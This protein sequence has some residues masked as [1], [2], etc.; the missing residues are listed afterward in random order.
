MLLVWWEGNRRTWPRARMSKKKD[1]QEIQLLQCW[2]K[3]LN[4]ATFVGGYWT[5]SAR[6]VFQL[7]GLYSVMLL[8]F[9][10]SCEL[11]NSNL[12]QRFMF[13]PAVRHISGPL[14]KQKLTST[15]S[16]GHLCRSW[17][18]DFDPF[19]FFCVSRSV[20]CH[21]NFDWQQRKTQSSVGLW[22][23]EFACYWKQQ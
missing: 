10:I 9:S 6:L 22:T 11:W 4:L 8:R 2:V 18:V 1:Q 17:L 15:G 20:G 23:S 14:G 21:H 3:D 7:H 5:I 13:F 16:K 19:C 12:N